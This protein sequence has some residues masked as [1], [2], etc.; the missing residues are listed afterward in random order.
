M[1][2]DRFK[3]TGVAIVTPF[4]KD[5]S[6]DFKS[7]ERLLEY[8]ISN[9]VEYVVAL[10]TTGETPVLSKD[11]KTAVLSHVVDVVN[12][13]LPVVAGMGGN[14]TRDVISFI[15]KTSFDGVDAILSVAPYYNKP[16]QKGIFEHYRAIASVSPVP[17]IIYNV[18]GRTGVN[19]NA[20]TT[21]RL[22]NKV[23]SNL[24]GI[25]EASGNMQQ[26][27]QIIRDKPD[28]FHVISGDDALTLPMIAA[29]A[30][31]VISVTANAFPAVF[32]EMVRLSLKGDFRQARKLHYSL[33]EI[34][35]L[36][37]VDGSPAGVKAALSKLNIVDNNLRLP[38]V[39][40]SRSVNL[41]IGE[42]VEQL[43]A[44]K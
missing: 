34:Y 13:R 19:I 8:I 30:S 33:M 5:D 44:K 24:L 18:P 27:M 7:L 35:H 17:V 22:A 42:V 6:I 38:L 14:N 11:E 41:R 40:V 23:N 25:K 15:Q 28:D 16:C 12:G 10:G 3:G 31:G 4:R 9:R 39:T 36:L 32:S 29:G 2:D 43:S 21:L 1:S 20:K 26:I 37:F